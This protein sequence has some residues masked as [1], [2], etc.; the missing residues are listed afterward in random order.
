MVKWIVV[1]MLLFFKQKTA[2]EMR[3]SDWSSDVCSS[4]L[5]DRVPARADQLRAR[6]DPRALEQHQ[7]HRQQ[8]GEP[9]REQELH[10]ERQVIPH[11]RQRLAPVD[12]DI[13]PTAQQ[14]MERDRLRE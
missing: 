11:R 12:A 10:D 13:A 3:I 8:E 2:Y 14:V 5:D 7:Q 1:A 9:E 4:D 6:H